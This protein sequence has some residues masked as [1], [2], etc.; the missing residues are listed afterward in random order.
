[1]PVLPR[2]QTAPFLISTP[3]FFQG[4]LKVSSFSGQDLILV[5]VGDKVQFPVGRKSD[6]GLWGISWPF[7]PIVLGMLIPRSGEDF[8]DRPG[9]CC[10]WSG[11]H[12][13]CQ[14]AQT[15]SSPLASYGPGK[16]SLLL[17]LPICRVTLLQSLISYVLTTF[18]KH[19]TG[20]SS[21]GN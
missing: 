5:E 17:L 21:Q 13:R 11:P 14:E 12:S 10:Y 1:M 7:Y 9:C 2:A 4:M 20:G 15:A 16:Y 19:C 3:N 18:T 8:A 6:R